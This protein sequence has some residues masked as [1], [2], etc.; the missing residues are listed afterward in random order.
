MRGFILAVVFT[1]N[2]GYSQV[3]SFTT[4]QEGTVIT[5]RILIDTDYLIETQYVVDPP[6]FILTRG[7]FYSKE[8]NIFS[9]NFEFNSNHTKDGLTNLELVSDKNWNKVS[10]EP[11]DLN[12][13][14]LMAGRVRDNKE[15]RRDT[16]KPRKTMKFLGDGFFQWIAFNTE[17]FEFFGSGGG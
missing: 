17:T 5:H 10:K 1:I 3:F 13:K 16:S 12:G 15:Q 8:G 7:G 14:W 9:I 11:L 2:F 6:Q 4:Q